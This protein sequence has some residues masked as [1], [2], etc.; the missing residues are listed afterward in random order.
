MSTGADGEASPT[1]RPPTY[2][3]YCDFRNPPAWA[4]P[5]DRFYAETLDQIAWA[6][7]ELGFG[8][9]WIS[10]H[11]FVADGYTPSP[12][13]LA[14]AVA[15]RTE[16]IEI[17]T[18]IAILP[19]QHPVRLAEDALTVD[20]L[21]GGRFRLGVGAGYRAQEFDAFDV[22]I[23]DRFTRLEDGLRIL[24]AAFDGRPL[25]GGPRHPELSGVTVTPG[26]LASGGPELW[27]GS[28]GPRGIELAA[29]YADGMVQP[30]PSLWPLYVDACARLGRR[31]RV[32]AGYHWILGDDPEQ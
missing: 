18:S 12:L 5:W 14:A 20:A 7:T 30:I 21:S 13:T 19:L 4:V 11:H 29:R 17:G 31:P 28:F 27:V 9:V 10:E 26:P 8:T 32:A 23:A 24:R 16:R 1:L 15:A 6:E 3:L 22:A 25:D 2:G